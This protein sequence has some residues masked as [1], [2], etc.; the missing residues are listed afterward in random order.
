MELTRKQKIQDAMTRKR[1]I[2]GGHD[3]FTPYDLID[4][5]MLN[6]DVDFDNKSIAVLY[7]V[8]WVV[9][10]L[11]D[12]EVDPKNIT[13]FGDSENKEKLA[14]RFGSK[15]HDVSDTKK[16]FEE[17]IDVKFDVIVGNPPYQ[18]T[19]DGSKRKK[20]W[21]L[22]AKWSINHAGIVA[23]ITPNAWLKNNSK[24]FSK[25][26]NLIT[27]KLV[28]FE[29]ANEYFNVGEDIGYWIVDNNTN[30]PIEVSD[31]NPC[32]PIYKKMLRDGEKW[33]YRDF[34]QPT[35]D[36]DKEKFPSEPMGE[37]N[38]PIYWT[39]K[40]IRYARK[41]DIKY[42]GWKVIVN[43]SGH[44]YS[45]DNPSKYSLVDDKMAVGLGAWGIKVPSRQAGENA[46]TWIQ[47]KLYRVVVTKMK[48]GGFNNPF[49]ELENLGHDYKWTD[50]DLY[51]YFGLTEEEINYIEETVK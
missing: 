14:L 41:K 24:Y 17:D 11:E 45:D 23:M 26:S 18:S 22:I 50:N 2:I 38:V 8:E 42:F 28:F 3:I 30:N 34:Q 49:V 31:G 15:Y 27:H 29:R 7:N 44:Y 16:F 36:I 21:V 12:W 51:D 10:L 37:F 9:S 32:T 13:F 6:M 48:T 46:L 47:S 4:D 43:N 25:I 1:G 20:L 19:E 35:S 5:V 33:H 39:A 40:Q